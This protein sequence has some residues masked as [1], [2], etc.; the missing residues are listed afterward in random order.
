M[1]AEPKQ[2]DANQIE[3]FNPFS[4]ADKIRAFA[5]N[6]TGANEQDIPKHVQ[7]L[8]IALIYDFCQVPQWKAAKLSRTD[9]CVWPFRRNENRYSC[10]E[11]NL[12]AAVEAHLKEPEKLI[13]P[14][15]EGHFREWEIK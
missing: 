6:W 10:D 8:I 11:L 13:E 15:G 4:R 7:R 3:P 5:L 2:V 12:Y 9:Y 1:K 14:E